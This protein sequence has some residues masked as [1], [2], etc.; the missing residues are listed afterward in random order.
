MAAR[1]DAPKRRRAQHQRLLL[2]CRISP[3]TGEE[4]WETINPTLRSSHAQGLAGG[5]IG[6]FQPV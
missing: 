1:F 3:D 2:K 5:D 6:M 4:L